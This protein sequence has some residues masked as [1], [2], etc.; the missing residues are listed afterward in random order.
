MWTVGLSSLTADSPS[1]PVVYV[2]P[3]DTCLRDLNPDI[4]G[5]LQCGYW[6]VLEGDILNSLEDEGGV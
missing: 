1:L 2:R 5:I 4:P 6:S 3:A